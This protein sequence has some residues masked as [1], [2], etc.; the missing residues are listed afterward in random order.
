M[1]CKSRLGRPGRQLKVQ[2]GK[3][4]VQGTGAKEWAGVGWK[5]VKRLVGTSENI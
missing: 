3:R 5:M 2:Q 1:A 4:R